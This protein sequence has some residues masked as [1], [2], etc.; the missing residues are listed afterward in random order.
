MENQVN[1]A[2]NPT[3][4]SIERNVGMACPFLSKH[5]VALHPLAAISAGSG[6]LVYNTAGKMF[7]RYQTYRV[8][9]RTRWANPLPLYFVP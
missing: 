5:H 9:R 8:F 2:S 4:P 1:A 6:D 3:K 7:V